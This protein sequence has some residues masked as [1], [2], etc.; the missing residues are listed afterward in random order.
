[1]KTIKCITNSSY[2]YLFTFHF[3][4][5][6]KF[7]QNICVYMSECL[8]WNKNL[9]EFYIF[10][11]LVF[12]KI[13]ILSLFC[14]RKILC[15]FFFLVFL[16]TTLFECKYFWEFVK[17]LFYQVVCHASFTIIVVIFFSLFTLIFCISKWPSLWNLKYYISF[18]FV[19]LML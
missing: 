11:F 5:N 9:L 1:M 10:L 12:V 2:P 4:T 8:F 16:Q 18:F 6:L 3:N 17:Y 15:F 14:Q 7:N 19:C 13:K